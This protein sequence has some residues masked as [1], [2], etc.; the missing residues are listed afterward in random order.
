MLGGRSQSKRLGCHSKIT[1]KME[2]SGSSKS[3]RIQVETPSVH[4][5]IFLTSILCRH[6]RMRPIL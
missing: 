4:G 5:I 6:E 1:V 3:W 2:H